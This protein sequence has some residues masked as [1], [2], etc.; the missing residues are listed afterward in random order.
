[1]PVVNDEFGYFGDSLW[2]SENNKRGDGANYYTREKHRNALW[3]IY[4]AGAYASIGD[5]LE[6]PD[7]KPYKSSLWHDA[8]EYEDVRALA[9]LFTGKGL[10]YWRMTPEPGLIES[11]TRVYALALAGRQYIF[12][13]A[14]GGAF[15]AKLAPGRYEAVLFNP[16]DGS[17]KPLGEVSG[18]A[19]SFETPAGE[20]WTV[21]LR[22]K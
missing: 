5:K 16:R 1:M 21:Y 14:A 9:A 22:A 17:E 18:P 7:G 3:A 6:Y 20:D 19:A 4:M 13:A 2:W 11:G 12:Y 15:R 10:E 8:A